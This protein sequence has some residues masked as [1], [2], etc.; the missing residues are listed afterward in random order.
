MR[1]F[2]SIGRCFFAFVCAWAG[3]AR[4]ETY[5]YQIAG[6]ITSSNKP[7]ISTGDSFTGWYTYAD[8]MPLDSQPAPEHAIYWKAPAGVLGMD[9]RVNST[10]YA[11]ESNFFRADVFDD[12]GSTSRFDEFE[13]TGHIPFG[14]NAN[15]YLTLLDSTHSAF[16]S[17]TIPASL[18]LDAFDNNRGQVQMYAP[19]DPA[20]AWNV[21]GDITSMTPIPEP[22]MVA[23]L[24]SAGLGLVLHARRRRTHLVSV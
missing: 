17:T 23:L 7:G 10:D 5:S 11:T 18:D 9:V 12:F 1:R 8:D 21:F 13:L 14:T 20:G 15:I 19:Y 16:A 4:A 3:Q 22:G 24:L 6:T 2:N